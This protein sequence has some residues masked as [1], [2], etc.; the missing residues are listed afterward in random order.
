MEISKFSFFGSRGAWV[1]MVGV[2]GAYKWKFRN[3]FF[4]GSRGA[5]E[6]MVGVLGAKN[7]FFEIC[8]FRLT[9]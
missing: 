9:R 3:L 5:W 2:L 6:G 8:F 1:G 7:F 4:F